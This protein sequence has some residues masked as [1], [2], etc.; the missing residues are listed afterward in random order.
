MTQH[1]QADHP[2]SAI[3]NRAHGHLHEMVENFDAALRHGKSKTHI[4]ML[5]DDLVAFLESHI[6]LE[7][8][9]M[10]T[11]NYPLINAHIEEHGQ[12]R[13]RFRAILEQAA[14]EC[15]DRGGECKGVMPEIARL[16]DTHVT[17]Y[18]DLLCRYLRDRYSFHAVHDG[19]GI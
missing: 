18:D 4:T 1:A 19:L 10:T 17:Y 9:L 8:Y 16:H 2:D 5:I 6:E 12:F 15:Y 3:I 13:Q 11:C 7:N 14:D